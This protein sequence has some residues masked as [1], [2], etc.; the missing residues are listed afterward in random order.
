MTKGRFLEDVTFET[1]LQGG[2]VQTGRAG[3]VG[4]CRWRAQVRSRPLWW[5]GALGSGGKVWFNSLLVKESDTI[6]REHPLKWVLGAGPCFGKGNVA[7]WKDWGEVGEP[8]G[9]TALA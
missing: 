3:V 4:A 7:G 2:Q 5:V 9:V 1:A 8:L 6:G